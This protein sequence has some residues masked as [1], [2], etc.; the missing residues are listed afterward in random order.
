MCLNSNYSFCEAR[1]YSLEYYAA[2]LNLRRRFGGA[3]KRYY[4]CHRTSDD[5]DLPPRTIIMHKE[6]L[7]STAVELPA[8]WNV[9]ATSCNEVDGRHFVAYLWTLSNRTSRYI[10]K[11]I[12]YNIMTLSYVIM[13][14]FHIMLAY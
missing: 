4:N 10:H 5:I 3:I 2:E 13:T 12:E 7:L 14:S 1:I 11:C 6:S 8:A 9:L